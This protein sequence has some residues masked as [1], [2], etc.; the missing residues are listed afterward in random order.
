M[1]SLPQAQFKWIMVYQCQL[2]KFVILRV[3]TSKRG[4]EVSLHLL[5]ILFLFG[6]SAI[7]QSGNSS[8]FTVKVISELKELIMVHGKPRHP[9]SQVSVE[10]ANGNIKDMLH[11]WMADNKTHE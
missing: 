10:R 5:N 7:L 4:T 8:E 2:T 6:A 11:A 1:Q 3:L 9:Q